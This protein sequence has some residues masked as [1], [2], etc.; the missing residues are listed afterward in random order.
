VS[1][2]L[3]PTR[4]PS[5]SWLRDHSL[6]LVLLALLAVQ[7]AFCLWAGH[8]VYVAEGLPVS[9]WVWWGWEY[10]VSLVADTYGVILVVLLTKWLY[11]RGSAE[12]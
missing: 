7:T 9:F 5:G 6:S 11:E 2:G 8:R 4:D 10:Q 12:S 3:F 1:T